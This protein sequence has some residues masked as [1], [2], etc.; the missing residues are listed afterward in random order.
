METS[1]EELQGELLAWKPAIRQ[2][3]LEI[4][5]K[6]KMSLIMHNLFKIIRNKN[7]D[8]GTNKSCSLCKNRS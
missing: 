1:E 8:K 6:M 4:A 3:V 2:A 5:Y 7:I